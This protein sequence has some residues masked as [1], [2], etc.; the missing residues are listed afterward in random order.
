MLNENAWLTSRPNEASLAEIALN[1]NDCEIIFVSEMVLWARFVRLI[2]F[3]KDLLAVRTLVDNAF[4]DTVCVT[5]L[6]VPKSLSAKVLK[7]SD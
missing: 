3:A 6:N 2:A 7:L 4:A 1:V 5:T